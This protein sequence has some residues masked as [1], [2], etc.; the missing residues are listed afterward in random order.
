[1]EQSTQFTP[2]PTGSRQH[3]PSRS[4]GAKIV[5]RQ[6]ISEGEIRQVTKHL[7][8]KGG[9][10]HWIERFRGQVILWISERDDAELVLKDFRPQVESWVALW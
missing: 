6:G 9:G 3:T 2:G 10:R 7:R 1:M 4:H 8:E 5:F